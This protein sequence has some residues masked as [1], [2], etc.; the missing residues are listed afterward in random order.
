MVINV[1]ELW[2]ERFRIDCDER[3]GLVFEEYHY[4]PNELGD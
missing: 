3:I 2:S 4:E 1:E